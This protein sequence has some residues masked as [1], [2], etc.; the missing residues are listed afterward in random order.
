M[1]SEQ[2]TDEVHL[3]PPA[4]PFRPVVVIPTYNNAN[5]LMD[6][7]RRTEAGDIPIIVVDDGSTDQTPALLAAWGGNGSVVTHEQNSGKASA[8]KTGFSIAKERGFTHAITLD[9]DGQLAPEEVGDFVEAARSHPM[10]FIIGNR[11]DLSD[12]YPSRSRIGRR[13]Q[14]LAVRVECGATVGDTLCGYRAYPLAMFDVVRARAGGFAFEIE[15]VTRAVWAG[16]KIRSIPIRCRYFPV[17]ERV[18]HYRFVR[19]W[20]HA[21]LVHIYLLFR[22]L[23]PWPVRRAP[24]AARW[25]KI[26]AAYMTSKLLCW[27]RPDVLWT[28]IR[29]SHLERAV[30]GGSV[31]LGVF[32]ACLPAFGIQ[33]VIGLYCALRLYTGSFLSLGIG[34]LVLISPIGMAL[35]IASFWVGHIILLGLIP[36]PVDVATAL[37]PAGISVT[38]V[39]RWLIGGI[40]LGGVL[41]TLVGCCVNGLTTWIPYAR[42]LKTSSIAVHS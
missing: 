32:A 42:A 36:L 8:L 38:I 28:Q 26:S 33:I 9:S 31:G 15:T 6:V 29:S 1:G 19:D 39:L 4:A 11:N 41:G 3:D 7:I 22:R 35:H 17:G 16:F 13:L 23:S 5:T 20:T 21:L 2:Q 12:D 24:H 18:S 37:T 34:L 14:N 27:L 40:I 25:N 10:D 30:V